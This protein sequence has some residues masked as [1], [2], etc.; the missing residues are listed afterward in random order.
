MTIT[1]LTHDSLVYK[2]TASDSTFLLAR[3]LD[4]PTATLLS[5]VGETGVSRIELGDASGFP[6]S[7]LI[8][9]G[10]DEFF[11]YSG[12][13]ENELTGVV[14]SR[15]GS[16]A[17]VFEAG[18]SVEFIFKAEGHPID[19]MTNLILQA[20]DYP[21]GLGLDHNSIDLVSFA[22][23]KGEVNDWTM[24]L[25][26]YDIDDLLKFFETEILQAINC[27]FIITNE[28][29]IGLVRLG[30]DQSVADGMISDQD[31]VKYSQTSVKMSDIVNR[32]KIRFDYSEGANEYRTLLE[33]TDDQSIQSF[34]ERKE[35]CL[36]Y[37]SPSPR[38]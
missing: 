1:G 36:L 19:I 6:E 16:G 15:L 2:F 33:L 13:S 30:I 21:V 9:I 31:I 8:L 34:G 24:Q 38:D 23:V 12:K 14:R 10:G 3:S 22:N 20:N 28:N 11:A 7:G 25:Y 35:I 26:I 27:R 17:G 18:D 37:T 32:I 5:G 29:R 4:V